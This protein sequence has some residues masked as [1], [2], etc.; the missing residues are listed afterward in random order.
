M[1]CLHARLCQC[2]PS[3]LGGQKRTSELLELVT[4]GC[5][6]PPGS[7]ESNLGLLGRTTGKRIWNNNN[8]NVGVFVLSVSTLPTKN[9]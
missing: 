1:F 9:H 6:P 4:D 2:V 8:E 7:W 5:D 3:A